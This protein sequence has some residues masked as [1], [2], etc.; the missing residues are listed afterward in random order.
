MML[1]GEATVELKVP[2]QKRGAD[3]TAVGAV[4]Q[5]GCLR[6]EQGQV[7]GQILIVPASFHGHTTPGG[8][9]GG[10]RNEPPAGG[11]YISASAY[12]GCLQLRSLWAN[13]IPVLTA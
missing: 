10:H 5:Q 12:G 11:S 13:M 3:A 6:L 8:M 1:P 2:Q 9:E 7:L 4:G